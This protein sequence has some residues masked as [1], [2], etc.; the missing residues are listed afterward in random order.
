MNP[1]TFGDMGPGFL[2]HDVLKL[3]YLNFLE[4]SKFE[5]LGSCAFHA[6]PPSDALDSS[7]GC[8]PS[9]L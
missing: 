1:N 4:V 7:A 5:T 2:N 3:G 9:A 6:K 8:M